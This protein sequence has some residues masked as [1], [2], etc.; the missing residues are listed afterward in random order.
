MYAGVVVEYLEIGDWRL[1]IQFVYEHRNEGPK[2]LLKLVKVM[3]N[4]LFSW[5]IRLYLVMSL[6]LPRW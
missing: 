5:G 6:K 2:N 4:F 3:N 1:K